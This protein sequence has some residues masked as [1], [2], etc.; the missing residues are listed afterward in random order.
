MHERA[1][2]RPQP[3]S[4]P[5][6]GPCKACQSAHAEYRFV[7]CEGP[8]DGPASHQGELVYTGHSQVNHDQDE[9]NPPVEECPRPATGLYAC[10]ASTKLAHILVLCA[11]WLY[12]SYHNMWFP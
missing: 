11:C 3:L 6:P 8:A 7:P 9:C 10:G 12:A 1:G 4:L 5:T 2:A